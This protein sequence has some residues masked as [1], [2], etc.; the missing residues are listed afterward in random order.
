MDFD[1]SA[2]RDAFLD[3]AEENLAALEAGLLRLEQVPDDTETVHVVFRAAHSIKGG[4]GN[5]GLTATE[6]L[7]HAV[8]DLL[9]D[10][11]DGRLSGD[12][13]PLDLLL[14]ATDTLA[15]LLSAAR[16]GDGSG[17]APAEGDDGVEA[18]VAELHAAR[19]GTPAREATVAPTAG[20]APVF[21]PRLSDTAPALRVPAARLDELIDL[22]GELV[23]AQAAVSQAAEDGADLLESLDTLR[24]HTR[25]LQDRVMAVRMIPLGT[26]FG[27][28]QRLVR[29][30]AAARGRQARLDV[31]GA[32]TEL[33]KS[34]VEM[35]AD[36]LTH[37]VRNAV[38]HGLEAPEVRQAAGKPP[39]GRVT[40]EARHESGHVVVTLADDGAGLDLA[41]IRARAVQ[42]GL[43]GAHESPSDA[44]LRELICEPG[45]STAAAVTEF[46]GRGVGLDVVRN[47][48]AALHGS[49]EIDSRPGQG[50]SFRIRLP[51][52][53]AILDAL[54][55]NVGGR[56]FMLPVRQV[57]ETLRPRTG[58]VLGRGEI[59]RVRGEPVPLLRLGALLGDDDHRGDPAA[60]LVVLVEHLGGPLGLLVD[61]MTE[62]REVVIKSLQPHMARIEGV[63]G[64]AILGDGRVALILD[65][66]GLV[67]LA[68]GRAAALRPLAPVASGIDAGASP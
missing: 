51:L 67:R 11:R 61:G 32:D 64:G 20:P 23:I 5:F 9:G 63:L 55:L 10:V 37:L 56:T 39:E 16:A 1:L 49:L 66:P 62:A 46:S 40:L 41:A 50:T 2:F 68:A 15:G 6:R 54:G 43:I 60:G 22:V 30:V 42:R 24:R 35:L 12:A 53:L 4:C 31:R 36:P 8:E 7:T 44:R 38:D 28:Y 29:A 27:R 48:I 34:M 13:A 3:E 59:V 65:V 57:K 45:F 14:R 25:E 21:R 17:E 26:L 52:T 47:N 58:D 18:L 33:D 19:E